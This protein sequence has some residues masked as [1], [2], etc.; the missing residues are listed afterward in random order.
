VAASNSHQRRFGACLILGALLTSGACNTESNERKPSNELEARLARLSCERRVQCCSDTNQDRNTC[1]TLE[2]LSA[3]TRS[4]RIAKAV[5]Q[6]SARYDDDRFVAC[7]DALERLSC[8]AWIAAE[9]GALP[10]PCLDY[11]TGLR[12]EGA[13]CD[14][15]FQCASGRCAFVGQATTGSCAGRGSAGAACNYV[16]EDCAPELRCSRATDQCFR[17]APTGASCVQG[18]DC[19]SLDCADGRCVSACRLEL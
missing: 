3:S 8:A 10:A 4:N 15:R 17:A 18:D 7:L 9:G 12:G 19:D 14:D 11:V 6:G 2:R 1:E 5:D 13:A 16:E